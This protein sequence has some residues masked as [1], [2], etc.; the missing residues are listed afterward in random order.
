MR[1]VGLYALTVLGFLVIDFV[2]LTVVAQNFYQKHLGSLLRDDPIVAAAAVFYLL[3]LVGVLVFVVLPAL[4]AESFVRAVALGALFGL[5]AY[6]TFDL[7]CYALFQGFPVIVVAV[8][9]VW[10]AV[11]TASVSAIGYAAGRWLGF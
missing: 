3:Y 1:F 4:Q 11:L 5:I 10:G 2:W 6:A 7:T 8:D 9:L